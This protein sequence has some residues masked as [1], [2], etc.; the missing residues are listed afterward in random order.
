MRLVKTTQL[1]LGN[2]FL[3]VNALCGC[4]VFMR[5]ML[6]LLLVWVQSEDQGLIYIIKHAC[7]FIESQFLPVCVCVNVDELISLFMW[8]LSKCV[9]CVSVHMCPGYGVFICRYMCLSVSLCKRVVTYLL[10]PTYLSIGSGGK[11]DDLML[12]EKLLKSLFCKRKVG[13]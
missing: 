4:T 7:L 13:V 1:E 9:I 5:A 11:D 6:C 3:M 2:V 10:W 12:R 8:R